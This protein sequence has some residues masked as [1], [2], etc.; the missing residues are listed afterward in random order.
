MINFSMVVGY[1]FWGIMIGLVIM[2]F[3]ERR[4]K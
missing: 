1:I 3:I 2:G 4:R